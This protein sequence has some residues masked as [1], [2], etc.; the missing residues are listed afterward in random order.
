MT[1]VKIKRTQTNPKSLANLIPFGTD[2]KKGG[3]RPK[4]IR[5]TDEVAKRL[6]KTCPLVTDR[7][8]TWLEYLVEKWMYQSATNFDY[9]KELITRLEGKSPDTLHL[10]GVTGQPVQFD[11]V[12]QTIVSRLTRIVESSR[13][14]QILIEP[15]PETVDGTAVDLGSVGEAKP[16][17]PDGGLAGVASDGGTGIR[18][19]EGGGGVHTP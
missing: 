14:Q 1:K 13:A 8:V 10:A 7:R 17:A 16:V 18:E 2:G 3:R 5:L 12:R 11:E 9:F 19:N 4:V 6:N 15:Q